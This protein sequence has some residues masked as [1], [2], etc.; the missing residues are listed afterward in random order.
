MQEATC[1]AWLACS[2]QLSNDVNTVQLPA[3]RAVNC[4][5]HE[6]NPPSSQVVFTHVTVQ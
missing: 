5:L 6:A 4:R 2:L 3:M 1:L